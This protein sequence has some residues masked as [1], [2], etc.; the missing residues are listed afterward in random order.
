M[1][2]KLSFLKHLLLSIWLCM[3]PFLTA[4]A[5]LAR[6]YT[7]ENSLPNSRVN[8]IYQDSRGFVWISTENGLARFDG[9][10][11]LTFRFRR[12]KADALAS[13]LVLT[14]F[15]DSRGT[16][17]TGTSMGL[18][19]FDPDSRSFQR[20]DLQ[21]PAYPGSTQ[22]IS[23]IIEVKT[24]TG[25]SEL[26][27][28]TSQ[29][30]IYIIDPLTHSLKGAR[31]ALLNRNLPS[32]FVY[33][34]F[35][36]SRG[37]VW[38]AGETGG[39]SVVDSQTMQSQGITLDPQTFIR[40]FEEDPATGNLLV[41]TMSGLY[42]Y[43]AAT[44]TLALSRDPEAQECQAYS[45]LFSK[46]LQRVGEKAFLVGT[47]ANGL[48]VYDLEKD[49]LRRAD[50]PSVSQ[51]I[52]R[53]KVHS[54]M[55]DNQGNIWIGAF[56]TG[57]LVVPRSMYGFEY[58]RVQYGSVS[59]IAR[60]PGDG[61]LWVGT[62]GGG[63][64][65]IA[66]DGTRKVFNA[67]NSGLTNNS[68]LALCFDKHG[69]LWIATY[70]DGIFSYTAS[71]GFRHFADSQAL[72]SPNVSCLAYDPAHDLL[73]AGT[74]G[75]GMSTISIPGE[76]VV[77]QISEDINKWVSALYID[78]SG[79]IWMG[80]YNGPMCYNASIGKLIS[81]NVGDTAVK[82]RVYCFHE[83]SDGRIW[84]GTGE[85]LSACD[86][87]TG[88]V[89]VYS[90]SDGLSSN[91]IDAI[92][93]SGDGTLWIS[94]SDGLNRLDPNTGVFST[95]Y[96]YDGL[97][98]NEFSLGAAFKDTDGRLFF[99]GTNG[100]TSFYPQVV[101]QKTH[102]VPPLYFSRLTVLNEEVEFDA[103]KEDNILDKP[104]TEAST[105]TLPY[106]SNTFS[107]EFA[108]LEYT[109]PQRI[110]YACKMDHFDKDWR[111]VPAPTHTASYTN[112]P[113]G[114][115]NLQVKAY[116]DGTPEEFSDTSI[117]IRI[118]PPWYL[119]TG[120]IASYFLALLA[121]LALILYYLKRHREHLQ[122]KEMS[123]IKELKL[124]MFTNISHEIRTPLTL[125]MSPL[126]QMREAEQDPHQ[127]DL[128]NLMYRN[129]LRIL[130]LVNQIMD[131]RKVDE[132]KMRLHFLE[133]DIVYF[134]RDI[135]QSFDNMAVTR[136]INL[137]LNPAA[138]VMNLWIDQGNF[139]K[140]VFNLLSNAFKHTP[141]GGHI[142]IG[143]S[144]PEKNHETLVPEV[145][146][147]V[148]MTITNSGS[149]IDTPD[150]EKV[151]ERF[152]QSDVL[153]AKMGSGVGLSLT[154]MLVELHHGVIT[155]ANT[156]DGVCFTVT[157]PV[158]NAHL[159]A[160]EM[161]ATSHHKDLY[162][163]RTTPEDLVRS[164]EDIAFSPAA[165]ASDKIVKSRRNVVIVD[166]DSE[167]R[168]YLLAELRSLY[169][170]KTFPGA[171][172]AW[173]DISATQPDVVVTDLVMSG[174]DGMELCRKI[175]H[176]PVTNHIPVIILTSSTDESSHLE[177]I[178][179]GADRFLSKPLSIDLLRS[180][181]AQ[182]IS[183][184]DTLRGKYSGGAKYDY[185]EVKVASAGTSLK[186]RV[187]E[188]VK[189]NLDNPEFGVDDLSREVGMSRVH[190]NRKL[191]ETLGISP[192]SF[193]KSTRMKQAAYLLVHDKVNISEVAYRVGFS[194]PSYF[195]NSFRSYFGMAPK[196]FVAKYSDVTDRETLDKL[197]E[198]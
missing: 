112:L 68:V 11:F 158:G 46:T 3:L 104:I 99:G 47:E 63:L 169:N 53:W 191:K 145:A 20:V 18:Q 31:R 110:R 128:Y 97:Q 187:M 35:Q 27:V 162:T 115:Y 83:A 186:D 66:P 176:N 198:V 25:T 43:R 5:Q 23:S 71:G 163:K 135:M 139:D 197:F 21:D 170:V 157:M 1:L 154:K 67:S 177:S 56:Q 171:Q 188:V 126:K 150:L 72:G 30:G 26:W 103:D 138:E 74:Y 24:G 61:S 41:A 161:S 121:L 57:V 62:D 136:N 70:L 12:D 141:D 194:T 168:D 127:K 87:N 34:L 8:Q 183:S 40:D 49:K 78:R 14:V 182:V 79:M 59:S 75:A 149:H 146:S 42:I 22:H 48:S 90:E 148:K 114:R 142:E 28:A 160:E 33:T 73:Y 9:R 118:L 175:R 124:K 167:I 137:S 39:L 69:T 58:T 178:D 85:G 102:P 52:S 2:P 159:T 65:R 76:K 174:M 196:E 172:E 185:D 106:K 100:I 84:I 108:V 60:N 93:E 92:L 13:D 131:M 19:V 180:S 96:A 147:L 64:M 81:Y 16:L 116:F 89:T 111:N 113:A 32:P 195:S 55:E 123:E 44:H 133:T 88:T 132:G 86:R 17:W 51:D 91:V 50:I 193:I 179:S 125:L 101:N 184:R 130:R 6:F 152:F 165:E 129:S 140:I 37:W 15:E 122:E 164:T 173:A 189:R 38:L 29:H 77:R 95:Y 10:D 107:L 45:L 109:N 153:D 54:L 143:I 119:T 181:I 151:F 144:A 105:I 166:D 4:N 155:A 7:T 80:T 98:G 190:L 192:S 82:A 120:A 134:I 117:A 156:E 94:T 36:D